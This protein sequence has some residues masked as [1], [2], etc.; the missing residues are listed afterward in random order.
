MKMTTRMMPDSCPAPARQR[1]AALFMALIILAA[2]TIVSLAALATSLVELR[3]SGN[4]ESAMK[5]L[6]AAQSAVENVIDNADQNFAVTGDVGNTN[7][8]S[9]VSGCTANNVTLNSAVFDNAN[10]VKITR[11]S[12][13]TTVPGY[14]V[15]KFRGAG[16]A[17]ESVFDKASVG[18]GKSTLTQGY[19]RIFPCGGQCGG[20]QPTSA[21]S[22]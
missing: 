14:S 8:T 17:V 5:A 20:N 15:D 18:Q 22:N 3:M 1:G 16:F 9:N 12:A 21:T 2:L 6:Q 10:R 4:T 13:E 19:V 11:Q 7:C